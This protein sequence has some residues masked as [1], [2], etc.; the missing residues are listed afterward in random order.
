MSIESRGA[1]VSLGG[2]VR[3]FFSPKLALDSG[4]RF[5]F[6]EF[7][8]G[9]VGNGSWNDMGEYATSSTTTRFNVGVS[10]FL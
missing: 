7:S 3:Y 5:T 9:R 8:E 4:L 1:G 10:Y 6:G 2:G